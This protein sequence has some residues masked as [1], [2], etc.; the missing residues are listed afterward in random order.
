MYDPAIGR[1][2]SMDPPSANGVDVLF[3][4]PF[5]YARNNP[6]NHVAAANAFIIWPWQPKPPSSD[7][8]R[9]EQ[10]AAEEENAPKV[11][12]R[13]IPG[14]P[15]LLPC[16]PDNPSMNPNPALWFDP[17][18]ADQKYHPG[19][20]WCMRSKPVG[21]ASARR[22]TSC[23][24]GQQCCFDRQGRLITGGPGAGTPDYYAPV[25]LRCALKHYRADVEP[26]W[27]CKNAGLLNVYLQYRPPDNRNECKENVI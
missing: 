8:K 15:C 9:C 13:L 1:F 22:P 26:F 16:R 2:L 11:W 23:G 27:W 24:Y 25:G 18:P 7:K 21:A 4:H 19:A 20:H 17:E 6:V 14:C 3:E 5:V 12:L 10:W